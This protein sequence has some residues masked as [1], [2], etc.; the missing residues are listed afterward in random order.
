[1]PFSKPN[2]TKPSRLRQCEVYLAG[3]KFHG[4]KKAHETKSTIYFRVIDWS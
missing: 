4:E 1:M 2:Q 3:A